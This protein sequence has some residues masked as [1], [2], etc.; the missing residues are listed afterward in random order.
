MPPTFESLHGQ[1]N[2]LT[3]KL[4]ATLYFGSNGLKG[5]ILGQE[6][7]PVEPEELGDN[8]TQAEREAHERAVQA[9]KCHEEV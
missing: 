8:P 4:A 7:A 2:W 5:H 9:R 6:L 3:W 1:S